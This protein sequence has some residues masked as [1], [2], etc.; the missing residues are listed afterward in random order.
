MLEHVT[1]LLVAAA[2]AAPAGDA[3]R[4][5]QLEAWG[6][7]AEAQAE[8]DA[9]L[10][11]DPRDV[12]ARFVAA[13]LAIER[14]DLAAAEARAAELSAAK[15]PQGKVLRALV[16]RRREVPGEALRDALAPAWKAAGRPDLEKA[17]VEGIDDALW[18]DAPLVSLDEPLLRTLGPGERVVFG[19]GSLEERR[20]DA[21]AASKEP[22]RNPVAVNHEVLDLLRPRRAEPEAEIAEAIA[23]VGGAL[24]G[25]DPENGYWDLVA[26]LASADGGAPL[27][28]AD[29]DRLEKVAARPRLVFPRAQLVGELERVAARFDPEHAA[30]RAHLAGLRMGANLA[31]LSGR[32]EATRWDGPDGAALKAR[33]AKV[34]L[35]LGRG[36]GE[37]RTYLERMLGLLLESRGAALSGAPEVVADV[38]RRGE[39]ERS[40]YRRGSA[41]ARKAGVWPF[42]AACREWTPD[43]V[44]YF[45]R[46][47][48]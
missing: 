36:L 45:E 33:T 37:S 42:A 8:V 38:R 30:C 27:T 28:A 7:L 17:A 43:E 18:I 4:A 41:A 22:G 29:L 24:A 3:R 5:A 20:G 13:C 2:L 15:V 26:W 44:A 48:D 19:P 32:A 40:R 23:R 10:A 11:R 35:R 47:L 9:A 21:V 12:T 6:D 25:V 1:A 16:A 34:L 39:D 31:A 14:G 46:F